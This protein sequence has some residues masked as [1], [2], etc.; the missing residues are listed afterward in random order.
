MS[1]IGAAFRSVAQ[2]GAELARQLAEEAAS[3]L[4]GFKF[5][6]EYQIVAQVGTAGPHGLWRIFSAVARSPTALVH[7]VSIWVLDKR[8]LLAMGDDGAALQQGRSPS[9]AQQRWEPVLEQQRLS[10]AVMTRMK[11]P[12][13]VRVVQPLAETSGHMVLVTEAVRGCLRDILVAQLQQQ[14]QQQQQ[15]DTQIAQQQQQMP[16]SG[17]HGSGGGSPGAGEPLLSLLEVK[18]GLLSLVDVLSFLHGTAKMAHCGMSP[19]SVVVAPDGSWKLAGFS[20]AVPLPGSPQQGGA[21]TGTAGG[22]MRGAA[23]GSGGP[24]GL[25]TLQ[26]P[27]SYSDPFPPPWEELAKPQ[28]SYTAPELVVPPG[29]AAGAGPWVAANQSPLSSAG[30]L[31]HADNPFAPPSPPSHPPCWA[32]ADA[33]SL[34]TLAYE[35][36]AVAA[37]AEGGSPSW[38]QSSRPLPDTAC[39]PQLLPVRCSLHQYGSR[40]AALESVASASGGTV[41]GAIGGGGGGAG[42]GGSS[43]GFLPVAGGGA[44]G[45]GG[46][47]ADLARV[48]AELHG[49]LLALVSPSPASRPPLPSVARLDWFE[50]DSLLRTLRFLEGMVQSEP[51][52]KLSFLND[53]AEERR[54]RTTSTSTTSSGSQQQQQEAIISGYLGGGTATGDALWRRLPDRLLASRVLPSLLQEVRRGGPVGVAALPVTVAISQR[55]GRAA[56]ASLALPQLTPVLE[57]AAAGPAGAAHAAAPSTAVTAGAG[58]GQQQQQQAMLAA[59]VGQAEVMA[60]LMDGPTTD[61]LLLPVLLRA[62]L[63]PGGGVAVASEAMAAAA[64]SGSSSS[65]RAAGETAGSVGASQMGPTAGLPQQLLADPR[66]ALAALGQLRRLVEIGLLDGR[67]AQVRSR[68]LQPLLAA[69]ARTTSAAVRTNCLG[70]VSELA[71]KVD[72]A[73]GE[74]I[75]TTCAQL[76][77]VD[78]SGGTIVAVAGVLQSLS[79]A[80]TWGP[81]ATAHRLLPMLVPQLV[82]AS[83]TPQQLTSLSAIVQSLLSRVAQYAESAVRMRADGGGFM[84][85]AAQAG[86]PAAGSRPPRTA[87]AADSGGPS[88][89]SEKADDARPTAGGLLAFTTWP[90]GNS[91]GS[92]SSS[93][94]KPSS[95]ATTASAPEAP[96]AEAAA[97][98]GAEAAAAPGAAV[99]AVA[100][101]A[102]GLVH[103]F[104]LPQKTASKAYGALSAAAATAA[105]AP[106][107]PSVSN[108]WR[109][110]TH[111][112]ST[113]HHSASTPMTTMQAAAASNSAL[114]TEVGITSGVPRDA[115]LRVQ[116][117]AAL[118]AAARGFGGGPY[119]GSSSSDSRAVRPAAGQQGTQSSLSGP[120]NLMDA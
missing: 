94:A 104:D 24:H 93:I 17:R 41:M 86:L 40:L 83:L 105:W 49:V 78:S 39:P 113:S 90:A 85:P 11:H 79:E 30:Q 56:F 119:L 58:P 43:L 70:L 57:A 110:D 22:W 32:A 37:L 5:H 4:S 67:S 38:R 106:E 54:T 111:T 34:G 109:L 72:R 18:L 9:Q 118:G 116:D 12:G 44:G 50:A 1:G 112:T 114:F 53:L 15:Q 89:S 25:A 48:P 103:S 29:G 42:G 115:P 45:A 16:P 117:T 2:K 31:L 80:P 92:P 68:L 10:C 99:G 96:G 19:Q 36:I 52:H 75:L 8:Q 47:A 33:F 91:N 6:R 65:S 64:A 62:V 84:P 73:E 66:L 101:T 97:A 77:S 87:T 13:V 108:S 27:Y 88:G 59:L 76:L 95:C 100:T 60:G 107:R 20:F 51:H 21:A 14:Q 82:A 55:L 7:D 46:A 63:G 35:T 26:P 102:T 28:L 120:L 81:V 23:T 69:A 3:G 98:P 71:G 61:R 74:A